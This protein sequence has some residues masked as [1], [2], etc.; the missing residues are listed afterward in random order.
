MDKATIVNQIRLDNNLLSMPQVISELLEMTSN[1]NFSAGKLARLILKDPA[2]TSKI[3]KMSNSSFYARPVKIKNLDNAISVLGITTVK[4]LALA[5]SI[6]Q[7]KQ[8]AA[9]AGIEINAFYTYILSVASGAELLAGVIKYPLPEEALIAGLLQD[10]GILYFLQHHPDEYKTVLEKNKNGQSLSEAEMELFGI[11]HCEVGS[12]LALTWKLPNR[13]VQSIAHH[14]DLAAAGEEDVLGNIVKLSILL[15]YDRFSEPGP[16]SADLPKK[17]ERLLAL[18]DIDRE[19]LNQVT[20]NLLAR[21]VEIAQSI[22]IDIN[23]TEGLLVRANQEIWKSYLK[24]E[25]L[26]KEHEEINQRLLEQEREKG[27]YEAKNV[28]LATLS[29]Y[30]NNTVMVISGHSELLA[31]LQCNG[32]ID[33]LNEQLPVSVGII[34]S[35]INKVIAVMHEMREISPIDEVERFNK[36]NAINIDARVEKRLIQMAM[37]PDAIFPPKNK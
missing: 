17:I 14:H 9:R 6:F 24:I 20:I 22:G 4:C 35:A 37:E 28:A 8:I 7:P 10:V 19:Q 11:T 29:H 13:I 25:R 32:E 30:L 33:K 31:I 23:D 2:I 15:T 1:D 16:D 5:T 21:M 36:S 3:L 12:L 34:K 27:A 26:F 18:L